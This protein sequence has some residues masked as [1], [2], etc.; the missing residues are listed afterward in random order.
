LKRVNKSWNV[1]GAT[2]TDKLAVP[3]TAVDG[4]SNEKVVL[5][6]LSFKTPDFCCTCTTPGLTISSFFR[7]ESDKLVSLASALT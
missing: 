3:S 5:V 1:C 2:V 4:I 7:I 6:V